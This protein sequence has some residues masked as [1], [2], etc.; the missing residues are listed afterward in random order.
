MLYLY[1]TMG[2]AFGALFRFMLMSWIK[3]WSGESFPWATLTVNVLGSFLLGALL[4]VLANI[5]PR[6]RELY[7]LMGIGALGG[8]TTFSAFSYDLYMLVER[9]HYMNAALYSLSS[10]V[11][12]VCALFFGMWLFKVAT[13]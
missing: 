6:G 9:G 13:V 11:V 4:A 1:V 8:F 5:M 7:L 2:G 3:Q 12:S 10:V